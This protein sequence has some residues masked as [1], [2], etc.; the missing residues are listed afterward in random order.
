MILVDAVG[1][2]TYVE[3]TMQDDATD[4]DEADWLLN[5]LEFDITNTDR[6]GERNERTKTKSVKQDQSS[7]CRSG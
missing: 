5:T 7:R 1:H 2:V 3:R 4:P 6:D